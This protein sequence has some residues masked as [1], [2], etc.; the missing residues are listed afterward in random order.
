VVHSTSII[1]INMK[2]RY[3]FGVVI[4]GA[5]A[6][7]VIAGLAFFSLR[8]TP[9][10]PRPRPV[11]PVKSQPPPD[12]T[13]PSAKAKPPAEKP[14]TVLVWMESTPPGARIV[15]VSNNFILGR[16]PETIGFSQSSEPVPVRFE[17]EGYK[18][19]T[20]EV[21][22]VSDGSLKVVLKPVSKEPAPE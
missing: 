9:A 8:E 14:F 7:I 18:P 2:I 21:P 15:L 16:T 6:L 1:E 10:P 11:L 17:L 13:A 12:K 20:R 5:S 22:A 19:V 3:K 4:I